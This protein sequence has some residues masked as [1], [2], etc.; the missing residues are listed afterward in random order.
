VVCPCGTVT[1]I[2]AA[3]AVA[4]SAESCSSAPFELVIVTGTP[5]APA[6]AAMRAE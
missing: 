5:L 6:G 4:A 3:P 2:D 1:V